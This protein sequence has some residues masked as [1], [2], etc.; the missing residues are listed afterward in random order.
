V[1]ALALPGFPA[2]PGIRRGVVAELTL[3]RGVPREVALRAAR[4]GGDRVEE[5][6]ARLDLRDPASR[7]LAERALRPGDGAA[8]RA[9]AARIGSHGTV[10]RD[11]YAV[12][13]ERHGFSVGGRLGVALGLAHERV[14]EERRLVDAIAWVNGGAPQHRFDCLGV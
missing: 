8:L 3:V 6:T 1:A 14:T 4:A 2:A 13:R 10:E 12:T 5:Y 9:L 7:A 11:G